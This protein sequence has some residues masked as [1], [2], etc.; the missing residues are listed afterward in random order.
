MTPQLSRSGSSAKP[1]RTGR[2]TARLKRPSF[3]SLPQPLTVSEGRFGIR[4][5]EL[6]QRLWISAVTTR[7]VSVAWTGFSLLRKYCQRMAQMIERVRIDSLPYG[8]R[9]LF[10]SNWHI[11][12]L[13]PMALPRVSTISRTVRVSLTR[14]YTFWVG[15]PEPARRVAA[16]RDTSSAPVS[17]N[18]GFAIAP[19]QEGGILLGHAPADRA[20]TFS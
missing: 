4:K 20:R 8:I 13:R 9:P 6:F 2:F 12:N 19:R 18:D 15:R 10:I 7:M 5:E 14:G 11:S 1:L 17:W 3:D 16:T